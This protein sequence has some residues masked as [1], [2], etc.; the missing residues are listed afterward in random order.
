MFHQLQIRPE[1]KQALRFIHSKGGFEIRNWVSNS[2]KVLQQLGESKANQVVHFNADKAK[3]NERVLGIVWEPQA[4][5]FTFAMKLPENIQPCLSGNKRPTKRIVLSIVMS[6]FDPLGLLTMFTIHGKMLIQD[7]WR[8]GCD[9]D[10]VIDDDCLKKWHCGGSLDYDSLKLHV[11]VD[12][13]EGAYGC[14]AYFRMLVDGAPRCSLVQAKS[15]VAPLRAY[16]TPRLEL[17]AAV[18]GA[19]MAETIRANHSLTVKRVQF[20]T[21]SSTVYS[22]IV[23]DHRR[24]KVFVAYRIGEILSRTSPMEW[25]W[26]RTKLNIADD[27][28][29]WKAGLKI[30][31]TSAWFTGPKFLLEAEGKWPSPEPPRPNVVDDLRASFLFHRAEEAS[32]LIDCTRISKW[33][34]TVRIIANV[35]R[36]VSNIRRKQQDLPIEVLLTDAAVGNNRRVVAVTVRCIERSFSREEY[37]AAECLLWRMAQEESF[38]DEVTVL[39]R[40]REEGSVNLRNPVRCSSSVAG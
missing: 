19:R 21:D 18:L 38:V 3:E 11:F 4:D 27:L 36:F 28:T 9:W 2:V 34:I 40:C 15:K 13:S 12:A 1:D 6:L 7:L 24:Y 16:S 39:R 35:L 17:M 30:E 25:R 32:G 20:W 10:E 5:V 22:W 31:S 23:S 29:K 8:S 14:V 33:T 26:V 37:Q